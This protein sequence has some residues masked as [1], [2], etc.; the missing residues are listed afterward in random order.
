MSLVNKNNKTAGDIIDDTAKELSTDDVTISFDGVTPPDGKKDAGEDLPDEDVKEA[1]SPSADKD[2]TDESEEKSDNSGE[3]DPKHKKS[4]KTRGGKIKEPPKP[5]NKKSLKNGS[6][7]L[8]VTALIIAV[9]IVVNLIVAAIPSKFTKFDITDNQLYSIG[10]TTKEI[11]NKLD[12]DVTFYYLTSSGDSNETISR[13]LDSYTGYSSHIKTEKKDL[14]S[15]PTFASQYTSEE[16]AA[17]SVIVVCGDKSK[18]VS[19]SSMYPTDASSYYSSSSSSFDGEG[20]L[21]SAIANV[22]SDKT[23]T[24]YYTTGHN[25]LSM[26]STMTDALSKSNVTTSELNL[27]SADIPDDCSMLMIFTPQS[28]F[29]SEEA[30]KVITYLQNGGHAMI[31]SL[32]STTDKPNFNSIMETYGVSPVSGYV[33]DEDSSHYTQSPILLMPDKKSGTA[34][35]DGLTDLNLVYAFA[36]GIQVAD[37]PEDATYTVTT[38]LSSSDNSYSIALDSTTGE[39]ADGDPEGPFPLAVSVEDSTVGTKILYYTTPC[40]FSSDA[41]SSLLQSQVSLPDGNTKLFS[42]SITYLTDATQTVSVDAKSTEISYN[43]VDAS[44]GTFFQMGFMIVLPIAILVLGLVFWI[45]R[46]NR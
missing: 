46:R 42:N 44:K 45:R 43:T 8:G 15:N 24:L 19:Y 7:F 3:E 14:T 29:T 28:D 27:L 35:S 18:Y 12:K 34:V 40:V 39:K 25:E 26:S 37:T 22:T 11:L 4:E 41:L 31:T 23:T 36:Q 2:K 13:L 33:V 20:Q 5:V 9:V 30:Q 32:T 17:N 16:V 1:E 6:Y 38:L 10:N 21:T